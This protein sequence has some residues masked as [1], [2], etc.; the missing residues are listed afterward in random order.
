M[1]KKYKNTV[2]GLYYINNSFKSVNQ[3]K[4]NECSFNKINIDNSVEYESIIFV[5]EEKI[6][7]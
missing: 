5:I 2:P 6:L 1:Y 7:N 4:I 3:I